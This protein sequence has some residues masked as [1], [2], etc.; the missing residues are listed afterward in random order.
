MKSL[1]STFFVIA[2]TW[3]FAVSADESAIKLKPGAGQDRIASACAVCHSLD[4]IQM[5]SPFLDRKGWET[6]VNKMAH[7]MGAPVKDEEIP[8]LVDYLTAQYG[9]ATPAKP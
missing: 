4:Y 3:A 1:A 5:N 9:V 7:V 2:S 8:A 6:V